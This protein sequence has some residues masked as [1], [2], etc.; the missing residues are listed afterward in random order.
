MYIYLCS[1]KKLKK[2]KKCIKIVKVFS[3]YLL[4]FEKK[5][6]LQGNQEIIAAFIPFVGFLINRQ[7]IDNKNY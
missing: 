6:W 7:E 3:I 5:R 2:K 4:I 1:T